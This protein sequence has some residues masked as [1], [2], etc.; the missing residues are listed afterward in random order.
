MNDSFACREKS[1]QNNISPLENISPYSN[2][3]QK[4]RGRREGKGRNSYM[5]GDK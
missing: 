1:Q 3:Y 5:A 2:E 4:Q